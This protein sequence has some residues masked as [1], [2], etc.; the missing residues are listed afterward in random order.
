MIKKR[1]PA[2]AVMALAMLTASVRAEVIIRPVVRY[3]AAQS[4]EAAQS[5]NVSLGEFIKVVVNQ[6]NGEKKVYAGT[7][8]GL[9]MVWGLRQGLTSRATFVS[10]RTLAGHKIGGGVLYGMVKGSHS[11]LLYKSV[12][13]WMIVQP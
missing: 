8:T 11:V 2:I 3:N 7:F 13:D 10:D 1:T 5:G 12:N 9:A 6:K 4:R